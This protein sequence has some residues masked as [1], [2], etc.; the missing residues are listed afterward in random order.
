MEALVLHESIFSS[1]RTSPAYQTPTSGSDNTPPVAWTFRKAST[2]NLV[3]ADLLSIRSA[4]NRLHNITLSMFYQPGPLN[5]MANDAS[6]RFDLSIH[7][8]L[9]LFHSKYS[10]QSLDY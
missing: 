2:I 10:P 9:T 6:C 7:P 1:I 4:H 8:F 5:T 3:V